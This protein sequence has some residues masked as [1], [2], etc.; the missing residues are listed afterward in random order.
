MQ[1][2][3]VGEPGVGRGGLAYGGDATNEGLDQI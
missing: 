2:P 1:P 3:D